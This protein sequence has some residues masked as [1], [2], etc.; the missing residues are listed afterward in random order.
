[1]AQPLLCS[2]DDVKART[3]VTLSDVALAGLIESVSDEIEDYC[4]AWLAPRPT[5]STD[6]PVTLL[7]DVERAG[8]S[9]RMQIA[10]RRVGIRSLTAF[11][12]ASTGQP[13]SGGTYSTIPL[14][15]VLFRPRPTVDGPATGLT[16]VSPYAFYRG[17]NTVTATGTFGPAAIAPRVRETAIELVIFELGKGR[18]VSSE[19]I[20]DWSV[21]YTAT[22]R[23]QIM[24]GL[25]SLAVIAV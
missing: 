25:G 6:P 20:G 16:L 24:S 23:D 1:M 3:T 2:T 17:F 19:S 5:L 22:A 18:G 13:E 15:S 7:F 8:N 9:L 12:T 21:G 11:G 14:A 10:N 4:G